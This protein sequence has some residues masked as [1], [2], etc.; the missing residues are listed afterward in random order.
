M[1]KDAKR[2][3]DAHLKALK[4]YGYDITTIQVEPSWPVSESCGARVNYAPDKNPWITKFPLEGKNDFDELEVPDF[5]EW[6]STKVMI[7]GTNILAKNANVPIAAYMTG[8]ITFSFQLMPYELLV[9]LMVKDPEFTH[10]LVKKS[11]KIIKEYVKMLKDAGASI[12]VLC[13]HDYQILK[14]Q[15]VE[16][17]SLN[18]IEELLTIYDFNILHMCGKVSTHLQYLGNI[19]KQIKKLDMI[20]I[21]SFVSISETQDLLKGKI[22]VAGNID[23]VRL[24]PKGSPKEIKETVFRALRENRNVSR[25]MIAPGCEITADTPIQNVKA[26]VNATKSFKR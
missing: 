20:S 1:Y 17:F 13:E 6:K 11:I 25:F 9:P 23:H 21:D 12:L 18:Y 26:L 2:S 10:L 7:E 4:L 22:G 15:Q 5:M 24:L 19:I 14:A 16:E 8:P 3:A